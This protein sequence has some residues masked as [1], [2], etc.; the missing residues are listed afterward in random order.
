M[1]AKER[2]PDEL[3][4]RYAGVR[5]VKICSLSQ[6]APFAADDELLT[7]TLALI[8]AALFIE[9][10][11]GAAPLSFSLILL[12]VMPLQRRCFSPALPRVR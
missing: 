11:A 12:A 7:R 6:S 1:S 5:G 8:L 9:Y 3:I 4:E 10:Y 2:Q